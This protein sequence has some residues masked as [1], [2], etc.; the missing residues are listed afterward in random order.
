MASKDLASC[1][2]KVSLE[3]DH[4]KDGA[5]SDGTHEFDTQTAFETLVRE[6]INWMLSLANGILRDAAQAEDAVQSAFA[7][8]HS[9]LAK[10]ERRASVKTWMHRIVANEALMVLRKSNRLKEQTLDPLSPEF[11]TNGCR[12]LADAVT[13]DTPETELAT[14]Q[15][16]TIV[17]NEIQALPEAYGLI[18]LLRD[19]EGIPTAEVAKMLDLSINNARVRLHRARA[20]L[21]KRLEPLILR[22]AI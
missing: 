7:K 21:K 9:G 18:L 1:K 3:E 8:I 15:T 5:G 20:A 16:L 12:I 10:F 14:Q 11:D 19:I 2:K 13:V 6:N 17:R 4:E 22:G